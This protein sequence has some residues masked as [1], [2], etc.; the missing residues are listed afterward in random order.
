MSPL[1]MPPRQMA[2]HVPIV[3]RVAVGREAV[4]AQSAMRSM[5]ME[6]RS[7]LQSLETLCRVVI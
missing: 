4:N 7:A 6:A 2:N 3:G 5:A 1:M